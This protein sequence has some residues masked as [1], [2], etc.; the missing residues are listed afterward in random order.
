M[1]RCKGV[2]EIRSQKGNIG[3]GAGVASGEARCR[4]ECSVTCKIMPCEPE[5]SVINCAWL[6]NTYSVSIM[7]KI[8]SEEF[9]CLEQAQET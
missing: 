4:N 6:D 8:T 1:S 9:L 2:I 3:I 7:P 5:F